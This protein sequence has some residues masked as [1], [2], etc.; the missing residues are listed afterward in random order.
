MAILR[1]RNILLTFYLSQTILSSLD[2]HYILI[3]LK[4]IQDIYMN[5]I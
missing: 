4:K 2:F 5:Y 3:N 1:A